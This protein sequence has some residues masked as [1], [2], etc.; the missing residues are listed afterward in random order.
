VIGTLSEREHALA[1]KSPA[2]DKVSEL[3]QLNHQE[4]MPTGNTFSE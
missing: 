4:I 3:S 2:S 1:S